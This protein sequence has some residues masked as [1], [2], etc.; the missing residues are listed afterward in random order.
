MQNFVQML[1]PLCVNAVV[2]LI[3]ENCRAGQPG[4]KPKAECVQKTDPVL[5]AVY[6]MFSPEDIA[7]QLQYHIKGEYALLLISVTV[8]LVISTTRMC[9]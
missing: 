4:V 5:E 8:N 2:L 1:G 3:Q 7:S 9:Q 6:S